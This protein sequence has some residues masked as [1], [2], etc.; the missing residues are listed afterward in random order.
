MNKIIHQ[1]TFNSTEDMTDESG[2][3]SF[4]IGD[5]ESRQIPINVRDAHEIRRMI[6]LAYKLGVETTNKRY[7]VELRNVVERVHHG[8]LW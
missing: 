3:M 8:L 7:S 6:D 5:V 2:L 4:K 1:F